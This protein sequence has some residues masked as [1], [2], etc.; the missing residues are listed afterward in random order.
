MDIACA[1]GEGDVMTMPSL[2]IFGL[3]Y[4]ASALARRVKARGWQVMATT[5]DGRDGTIRFD[6]ERCVRQ[7]LA[8]SS[9]VLSSVPPDADGVDPVLAR[10]GAMLALLPLD[11][12]GYLSSTGVYGDT[13]GAWVDESAPVR[14]R[15]AAR[16]AADTD[17]AGLR[18]DM[19]VFRLPGIY[20]PGRSALDRLRL[21]NAHRV[22]LP[23]QLFSRIH[24]EDIARGL[25]AS[26]DR[27]AAGIFNLADDCPAAQ[28]EVVAYAA[29]LLGMPVPPLLAPD[30][31]A[32]SAAA[33][34]F[35]GESRRVASGRARRLL[36]WRPLYP[37][38]RAGLM[39]CLR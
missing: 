9:H 4:S 39:T 6:D 23:G 7:A 15:R 29:R 8:Q 22:D 30:D 33:R 2:L 3:G 5:R 20:G 36:G 35:H 10:Y 12:I 17:W 28:A 1:A 18:G 11:W 26:M 38:Y 21:G 32:I 34:A 16:N 24:V 25:L 37:D 13:G 19:R 14:G 27:S 31:P